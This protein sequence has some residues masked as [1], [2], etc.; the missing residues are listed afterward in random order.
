KLELAFDV[1]TD[2]AIGN[3]AATGLDRAIESCVA[4]AVFDLEILP[5]DIKEP[6]HVTVT[7]TFARAETTAA[8][9]EPVSGFYCWTHQDG[10]SGVCGRE[11]AQ[12]KAF[13]FGFND[14]GAR[15]GEPST[16]TTCAFQKTAWEL[17]PTGHYLPTRELCMR[18]IDK[19]QSCKLVR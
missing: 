12:C 1:A 15:I 4:G 16:T 11:E 2:G 9:P 5:R 18:G 17:V 8:K 19:S 13:I 14:T 6:M 3:A 10:K 7:I